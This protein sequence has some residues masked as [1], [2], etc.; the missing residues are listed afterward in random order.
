MYGKFSKKCI[1]PKLSL[2]RN[3]FGSGL[4]EPLFYCGR[5]R[6]RFGRSLVWFQNC[7]ACLREDPFD[8]KSVRFGL[9][10]VQFVLKSYQLDAKME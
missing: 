4:G 10:S 1:F 6:F 5:S 9:K 3:Y 8:L 2:N 7:Q